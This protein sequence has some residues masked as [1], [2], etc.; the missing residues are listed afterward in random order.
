MRQ[1]SEKKIAA[2]NRVKAKKHRPFSVQLMK[3]Y[4][5][6]Y[7]CKECT[8]GLTKS[9]RDK[10]PNGCEYYF[11]A[12]TGKMFPIETISSRIN[13]WGSVIKRALGSEPKARTRASRLKR[14]NPPLQPISN[15]FFGESLYLQAV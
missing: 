4:V 6:E 5:G 1:W 7:D 9:C 14:A 11:N 13:R 2:K 8:H 3:Q 10:L 15:G 12:L